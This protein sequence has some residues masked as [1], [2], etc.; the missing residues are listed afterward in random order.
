MIWI[1]HVYIYIYAYID[2]YCI[3][4]ET[5]INLSYMEENI[6]R[7]RLQSIFFYYLGADTGG[8]GRALRRDA[9][10]DYFFYH[11]MSAHPPQENFIRTFLDY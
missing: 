8:R 4:D 9:P 2:K 5:I 10:W 7:H 11:F 1:L 6:I 3:F